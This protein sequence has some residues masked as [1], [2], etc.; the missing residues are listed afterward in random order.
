MNKLDYGNFDVS[1][2]DIAFAS[3]SG[4]SEPAS[5]LER[6]K[7][8]SYPLKEVKTFVNNT[9]P[10]L[11]S[12]DDAAVQLCVSST[13]LK[14]RTSAGG[15]KNAITLG[16]PAGGTTGQVLVKKSNTDFDTEW[17]GSSAFSFVGMVVQGTNLTTEASV[18]AIYGDST[19]WTLVSSVVLASEHVFGNGYNLALGDGSQANRLSAIQAVGTNSMVASGNA[20]GVMSPAYSGGS[21]TN[22]TGGTGAGS[23]TKTALGDH[24]EYSGLIADTKTVYSWERTA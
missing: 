12:D 2:T 17:G 8:L 5:E 21:G 10:V 20:F 13:G 6:R 22:F 15:T 18:K 23:P 14:Y 11:D 24:P 1:N 3:T 19:S 7:Q 16:V 9:V 4:Y